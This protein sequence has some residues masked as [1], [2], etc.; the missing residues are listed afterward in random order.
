MLWC[1]GNFVSIFLSWQ[2]T[3][4]TF[5][6]SVIKESRLSRC[7]DFL[8]L[9][10]GSILNKSKES[11]VSTYRQQGTEHH[12]VGFY[13]CVCDSINVVIL[14]ESEPFFDMFKK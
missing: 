12:L 11:D 1:I 14:L 7:A 13:V 3:T 8:P 10:K 9:E 2:E 5:F 4:D 6:S